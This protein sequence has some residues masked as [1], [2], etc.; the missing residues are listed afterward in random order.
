MSARAQ[1][2]A[3]AHPN[4]SS[5]ENGL[6]DSS[7]WYALTRLLFQFPGR[8]VLGQP[9]T[10]AVSYVEN[11]PCYVSRTAQVVI[12]LRRHCI[13][14]ERTGNKKNSKGETNPR[15]RTCSPMGKPLSGDEEPPAH[16][17]GGNGACKGSVGDEDS[18]RDTVIPLSRL[19]LWGN[20]MTVR[21]E[22]RSKRRN[23][24]FWLPSR[25]CRRKAGCNDAP[26]S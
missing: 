10:S 26:R 16:Q 6:I 25:R 5:R 17:R 2:V 23:Q 20:F 7:S 19:L 24:V 8:K 12:K 1:R 15:E 22:G 3:L 21:H 9:A 18:A 14:Q 11:F 4:K 13:S